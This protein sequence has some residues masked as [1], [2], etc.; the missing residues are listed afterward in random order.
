MRLPRLQD[1]VDERFL[2]HRRRSTSGAGI[3]GGVLALLLFMYR[4]YVD[5]LTEWDLLAVGLTFVLVKYALFL[6]Y[7]IKD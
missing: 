7:R 6:W 4:F 3:V 2:E 5:H 1:F